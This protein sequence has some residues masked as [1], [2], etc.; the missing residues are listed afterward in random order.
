MKQYRRVTLLS[1]GIIALL[2]LIV[3]ANSFTASFHFDDY[4]TIV[5]NDRIKNIHD[6]RS[7]VA[8][9]PSRPI[10]FLSL[11][12]NYHFGRLNT[13]GYHIVNVLFHMAAAM[14]VYA[15]ALRLFGLARRK[16]KASIVQ[17][18]QDQ[19]PALF[20]ALVFAIHPM[21]TEAVTYIIQRATVMCAFFYLL[22]IYLFMKAEKEGQKAPWWIAGAC[23]SFI[24]SY[25][26]KEEAATLPAILLLYDYIFVSRGN[27]LRLR[28]RAGH[29]VAF[30]ILLILSFVYRY[31][32][33][34]TMVNPVKP[35]TITTY[36]FTELTVIL[37]Y[38]QLLLFPVNQ[39]VDHDYPT[40]ATL[41]SFWPLISLAFHACVIVF[42]VWKIRSEKVLS[43]AILWFYITLT[44]T[45]SIVPLQ[46]FMAEHRVYLPSVGFCIV[47]GIMLHRAVQ[48]I[49][50]KWRFRLSIP[51]K[52]KAL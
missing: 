42:A 24:F 48:V 17:S 11:A 34:G 28:A 13:V 10:V 38:I 49:Q 44:P 47:V 31:S 9:N 18:L 45:S 39:N 22:A 51:A 2:T 8:F 16:S 25:L 37:K 26:C 7:I 5:E 14:L 50:K 40:F 30:W 41:L 1:L 27:L 29:H 21:Q 6:L 35:Y 4:Y 43:F 36:A 46:D 32:L 20:P 33:Y 19:W 15:I 52:G 3:Y 12:L 23:V